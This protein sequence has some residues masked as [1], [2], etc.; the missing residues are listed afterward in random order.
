MKVGRE[1]KGCEIQH[2][3]RSFTTFFFLRAISPPVLESVDIEVWQSHPL[4]P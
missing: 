4:Q 3:D 2:Q 1:K